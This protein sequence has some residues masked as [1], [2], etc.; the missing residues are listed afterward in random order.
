MRRITFL[1][2]FLCLAATTSFGGGYQVGLHSMRNIGMGLIGTSLSYDASSLF[3]NPGGAAFVNEKWSFSGGVSFL[4]ARTTFQAKDVNYQAH[5]KH[6]INTPLYFYAAFKPTPNLSVGLAVNTPYGNGLSWG[7]DWKGR[8]LIQDLK[9]SAF[10]FQPT[11][12][13]KFKDIIGIGVGLVYAYGSVDLNKAI[14]LQGSTGDGTLNIKGSTGNFGF[15]AGLMVHPVKGLSIGV[16]YRSKIQMKVKGA[17][18][19]FTVPTSLK[20]L[21]PDNKVDVMLPL[22]ANLDFGASYE[23]GQDKQWMI[24]IN[25]CYVFWNTYDSLVFDFETKTSA[26]SRTATPALYE[27]K[28]I[29]RI[30]VQYKLSDLITLRVGGYYDPSPVKDDYLNPQTPSMNQIGMT[31]GISIFPVK[32]LSIDAAFLYIMGSERS[33]TYSPDNFAGTYKNAVYN[34]GIGLTYNF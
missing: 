16:D 18:A 31:C 8:Y 5:L 10:T 1:L 30:G 2:L 14:P 20:T 26:V 12:S 21:F 33:G 34:P 29:P 15:N 24:G 27:N 17:T 32:G 3:Y 25:L 28:L 4:M 13:Y 22:P 23:F 9:F 19:T 11:V 7:N 6:Q